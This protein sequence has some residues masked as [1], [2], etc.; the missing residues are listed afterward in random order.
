MLAKDKAP[1]VDSAFVGLARSLTSARSRVAVGQGRS[2]H[3]TP[4]KGHVGFEHESSCLAPHVSTPR[5]R[6]A[7]HLTARN[8]RV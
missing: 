1:T 5:A 2:A 3:T 6:H 8:G 7:L 4:R